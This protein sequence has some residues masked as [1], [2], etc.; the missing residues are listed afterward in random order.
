[1]HRVCAEEGVGER[2]RGAHRGEAQAGDE[3][4]CRIEHDKHRL[5]ALLCARH[6]PDGAQGRGCGQV[7]EIAG[8]PHDL[9]PDE[10]SRRDVQQVEAERHDE[11]PSGVEPQPI[12]KERSA[13]LGVGRRAPEGDGNGRVLPGGHEGV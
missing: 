3:Q 9:I 5:G 11:H 1:M 2:E 8:F 13:F 4:S 7:P 12:L 10:V 6:Q